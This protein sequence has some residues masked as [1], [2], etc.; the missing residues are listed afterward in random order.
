M[1]IGLARWQTRPDG[2][3]DA[4]RYMQRCRLKTARLFECACRMGWIAR[5]GA[6]DMVAVSGDLARTAP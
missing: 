6:I 3:I 1:G 4:E 5:G 2:S